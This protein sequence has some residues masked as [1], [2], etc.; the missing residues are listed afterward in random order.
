MASD[1]ANRPTVAPGCCRR[2]SKTARY[3]MPNGPYEGVK[4]A[5]L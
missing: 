3:A 5:V 1:G 2:L 4:Q